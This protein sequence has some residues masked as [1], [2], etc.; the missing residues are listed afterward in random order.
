MMTVSSTGA[1]VPASALPRKSWLQRPSLQVETL[2]L[3]CVGF[4]L[5]S[6]NGPFWRAALAGRGW[7]LLATWG[8]AT[9]LFTAF[10]AFYFAFLALLATR[11]TV[12]PLLSLLVLCTAFAAWYMDHYAIYM[13]RAMLRNVLATNVNEARELLVWGMVPRVVLLGALPAALVWWPQLKRRSLGRALVVRLGWIAAALAVGA[14]S[15]LLVFADFASLMR[16]HKEVRY[17]LT[18]G[19]VVAALAGNALGGVQRPSQPKLPVGEDA[20]LGASWSG[21]PRPVMFVLIVG[22]TARAQNFSLNGYARQTNPLLARQDVISFPHATACGTSTEVSLPCMF[23]PYGRI[24]YDEG[25]IRSHESVLHVL[26]RAGFKVLWRD[27]QSGCKGVCEGLPA[28][29]LDHAKVEA[30]CAEGQCLDE[31]LLQGMEGIAR[32]TQGNLL[33]VMHQLGSHGPAYFKRYP[34]VF[35]QFA[36]ACQNEDLSACTAAEI[37]NAY[38]N[39]LLYTDFF[40]SRVID[41]LAG[42]QQHYDTAMVYVSDHGESLGDGGLYLHGMP[43]P[44][45]PEVQKRVPL[46]MW[47]SPG[48]RQ[49]FNIDQEC[50]RKNAGAEVGHDNL[51][52]SLLGVLDVQTLSYDKSLDLFAPCRPVPAPVVAVNGLESA[53]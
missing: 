46:V 50:L 32:D 39:S 35:R 38:D 13:D 19:N 52:H 9:A 7:E 21:R 20:R 22:E 10:S 12:R 2:V 43:Y 11:L 25:K 18:P 40:V 36:P 3:L 27:N 42:A 34:A 44:I 48:F 45:A 53:H 17:L 5:L 23:S 1:L 29:Q 6:G 16:N 37:V 8:F 31:V 15:L 28:E 33:V 41:F 49:S 24:H 26:A 51:F 4:L 47:L 30:L 14:A